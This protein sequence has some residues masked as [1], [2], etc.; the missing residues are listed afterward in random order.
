M[1]F[2]S[3]P[4]YQPMP[5]Q[6]TFQPAPPPVPAR[7]PGSVTTA[8]V[9]LYVFAGFSLIAAMI[10]AA[11]GALGSSASDIP[12]AGM[13]AGR[14]ALFGFGGAVL[15][16]LLA[17]ADI[18]L[19]VVLSRGRRWAQVGTVVLAVI[20]AVV[21]LASPLAPLCIVSALVLVVLVTAP[22]TARRHFASSKSGV[23]VAR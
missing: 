5:Y 7:T 15:L 21:S 19:G 6:P 22:R 18:V 12:I 14:V 23:A 17:A 4:G 1:Q 2:P 16:V 10:M 3:A 20:V 11:G 8:S 13:Y 9:L